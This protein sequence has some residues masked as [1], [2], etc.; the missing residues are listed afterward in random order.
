MKLSCLHK[1]LLRLSIPAISCAQVKLTTGV[2]SGH[3]KVGDYMSFQQ[4]ASISPGNSGG[5]LFVAGTQKVMGINFAA[6]V[7]N[8]SRSLSLDFTGIGSV[9]TCTTQYTGNLS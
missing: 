2:V 6:A 5:P 3:E 4:T 1:S 7:G 8:A 9:R